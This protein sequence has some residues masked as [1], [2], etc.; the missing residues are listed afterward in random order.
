[1][2]EIIIKKM[3]N[4]NIIKRLNE[5]EN[6]KRLIESTLNIKYEDLSFNEFNKPFLNDDIHFNVSHSKGYIGIAIYSSSIGFDLEVE[7]KVNNNLI[8][9]IYNEVDLKVNQKDNILKVFT[10]KEAYLKALGIGLKY[11]FKNIIIDYDKFI[12]K[13]KD[14]ETMYFKTYKINDI[15]FSVVTKDNTTFS[16]SLE[17]LN[18]KM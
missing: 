1:M 3:K 14:Y 17:D 5:K 8:N 12:V 13:Y 18:E 2:N 9:K 15:I 6:S 4:L 10:I 16:I 7:R 11:D